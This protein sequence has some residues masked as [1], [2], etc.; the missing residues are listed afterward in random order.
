MSGV[1]KGSVESR[2]PKKIEKHPKAKL[3]LKFEEVVLE[4]NEVDL[5]AL[6]QV[7]GFKE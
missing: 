2:E 3:P 5:E 1:R 6:K 7:D 4:S